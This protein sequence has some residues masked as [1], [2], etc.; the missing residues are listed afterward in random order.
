VLKQW[1]LSGGEYE[2]HWSLIPPRRP[3]VP[4][5]NDDWPAENPIDRFVQ[6]QLP[7]NG[8][9]PAPAASRETLIRRVT[10][11]LL[12]LPPTPEDVEQFLKD[13]RPDAYERLVDRLLASP[14]YGERMA[15]VWLD[16]AR[17][18]DSGGYQGDIL[19]SMWLWRD[20]VIRAYPRELRPRSS[21]PVLQPLAGG[22][23]N[24][25]RPHLGGDR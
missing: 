20:W 22:W 25:A 15:L 11:D 24:Q 16:A 13:D 21:P 7:R 10:L 3:P 14:H 18:A 4:A 17:F 19:R 9:R 1:V 2:S 6:A 23:G 12:G 5:A 8:L